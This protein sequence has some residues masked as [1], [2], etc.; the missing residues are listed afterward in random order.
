MK[1]RINLT[2][3]DMIHR[4]EEMNLHASRDKEET[5]ILREEMKL[6][7]RGVMHCF[8]GNVAEREGQQGAQ[9]RRGHRGGA[10]RQIHPAQVHRHAIR[11]LM[12]DGR[13][14]WVNER[15]QTYYDEQ[16]NPL[17]STGTVQDVTASKLADSRINVDRGTSTPSRY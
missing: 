9:R 17:R 6:P 11:L 7:L 15:C 8:S 3:E 13:I 2:I 16:G 5:K 10:V 12:P 4:C 1:Q 14:K